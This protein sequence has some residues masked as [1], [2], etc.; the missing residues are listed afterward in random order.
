MNFI[1]QFYRLVRPQ[2]TL[3][4]LTI[5]CGFL[6]VATNL[7]P[8]F[9]HPPPHP[10]AHR[11]GWLLGRSAE[12]IPL[13]AG[14]LPDPGLVRYGYGLYSHMAAYQVMHR[15]MTRVYRHLQRM[16]HRFFHQRRTGELMARSINDVETVEDFIHT[17]FPR[18]SSPWSFPVPC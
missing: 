5:G 2:R 1:R 9:G 15:L 14:H 12:A 4:A 3:L 6:F 8:P 16:P 17:A 7:L 13:A 11:R 18:P 10:M